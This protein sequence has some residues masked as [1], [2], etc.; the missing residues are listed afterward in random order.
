MERFDYPGV[1][2][3]LVVLL[4]LAVAFY[5]IRDVRKLVREQVALERNRLYARLVDALAWRFVDPTAEMEREQSVTLRDLHEFSF[6]VRFLDPSVK[7]DEA[8][9]FANY[10]ALFFSRIRSSSEDTRAGEQ[11]LTPLRYIP[12]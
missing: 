9:E 10:E 1:G 3:L 12:R 7:L 6:L 2:G 11:M 5:A 8:Q 4:G